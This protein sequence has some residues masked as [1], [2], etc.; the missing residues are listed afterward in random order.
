MPSTCQKHR[1]RLD[2]LVIVLKIARQRYWHVLVRFIQPWYLHNQILIAIF[3]VLKQIL[4]THLIKCCKYIFIWFYVERER[5]ILYFTIEYKKKWCIK[6]MWVVRNKWRS[7]LVM[8]LAFK[9]KFYFKSYTFHEIP[10]D[11]FHT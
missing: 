9:F 11:L 3:A 2:D 5:H 4:Y 8:F 1:S 6:L 10:L 7:K